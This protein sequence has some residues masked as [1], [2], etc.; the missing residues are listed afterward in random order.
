MIEIRELYIKAVIDT[1]GPKGGAAPAGAAT[2]ETP[3]GSAPPPDD[4]IALCVEKVMEILKD[5]Q[6]R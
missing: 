6:E 2:P 5:K 4:L 1:G 3:A